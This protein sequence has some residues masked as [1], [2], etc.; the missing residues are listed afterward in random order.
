MRWSIA[1]RQIIRESRGPFYGPGPRGSRHPSVRRQRFPGE[2]A[3][4]DLHPGGDADSASRV[5][6][7]FAAA[8]YAWLA[9]DR[10][11]D[12][13]EERRTATEYVDAA[14][15]HIDAASAA[16]LRALLELNERNAADE[17][18]GRLLRA[19]A[20]ARAA[21]ATGAAAAFWRLAYQSATDIGDW[22][23]AAQAAESLGGMAARDG[24][25]SA[26][27]IWG[28]RAA[29]MQGRSGR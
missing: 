28:R 19:G 9:L 15:G 29:R 10:A 11:P 26:A 21:L 16:S 23:I 22:S 20:D 1:P 3:L 17:A 4:S 18:A 8:R 7:R 5:L 12:L 6:A 25:A 14:A 27:K 13:A 2:L 24:A